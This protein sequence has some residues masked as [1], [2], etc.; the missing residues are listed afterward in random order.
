MA[1]RHDQKG[2]EDTFVCTRC[3]EDLCDFCVDVL[4]AVYSQDPICCC[5]RKGHSGE[6]I[7]Q[8]I[9][10]PETNAVHTPGLIVHESGRVERK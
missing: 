7:E 9:L 1:K 2:N 5:R 6:P 4:R 10:D 8:Q 3:K